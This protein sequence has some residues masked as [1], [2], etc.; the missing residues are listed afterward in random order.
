MEG[1]VFHVFKIVQM[2]RNRATHHILEENFG[3]NLRKLDCNIFSF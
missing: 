1:S 3:D 2:L